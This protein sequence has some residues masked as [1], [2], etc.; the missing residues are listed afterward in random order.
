MAI[1]YAKHGQANELRH[2]LERAGIPYRSKRRPN[3]LNG[4]PVRQLL[5]LLTY[6]QAEYD[7]PGTG[8]YLLFRVLHF[9]C[10]GLW[11]WVTACTLGDPFAVRAFVNT[12]VRCAAI[13][14]I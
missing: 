10:F 7:R 13:Q 1:I 11:P 14:A 5:D 8:E 4:R 6:L 12:V 3:V 9:R 2:L